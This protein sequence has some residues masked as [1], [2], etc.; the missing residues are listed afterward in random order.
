MFNKIRLSR[1]E[2]SYVI[3]RHRYMTHVRVKTGTYTNYIVMLKYVCDDRGLSLDSNI[4]K[5][6]QCLLE[7]EHVLDY[8]LKLPW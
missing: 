1:Y 8:E 4:S 6:P 3:F 7:S 5:G 2:E